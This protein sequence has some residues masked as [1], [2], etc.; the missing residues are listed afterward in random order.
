VLWTPTVIV[1]DSGGA[2]RMRNEGYMPKDEFRAW[3]E[4]SLARL[5]FFRKDWDEAER[6][7]SGV[8]ASYPETSFAPE[9]VYW[10]GVSRYKRNDHPALGETAVS[11]KRDYPGSL[12]AAKASVWGG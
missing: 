1:M 5:A 2:E 9:A 11:L 7:Y 8:A 3:L 12:W 6:R 4:M 10:K